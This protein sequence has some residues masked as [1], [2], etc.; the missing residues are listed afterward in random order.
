MLKSIAEVICYLGATLFLFFY[1][2]R[3]GNLRDE[4]Q[5]WFDALVR[6]NESVAFGI[7]GLMTAAVFLI[8]PYFD[9]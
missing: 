7:I 2:T 9:K 4:G 3:I 5:S 1:V 6:K 8:A